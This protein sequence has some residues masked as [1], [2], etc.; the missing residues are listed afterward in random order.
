METG[1]SVQVEHYELRPILREF[2]E[3]MEAVLRKNDYKGGWS[4]D[5]CPMGYLEDR[6]VQEVGEYRKSKDAKELVDIANFA[7]MA[8]SRW[9]NKA[10]INV[11]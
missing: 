2:A 9:L 4:Q 11:R 6:L 7:M 8:W 5:M 1:Q 10:L 3:A